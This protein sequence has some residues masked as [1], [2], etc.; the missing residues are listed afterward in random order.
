LQ[1]L[2]EKIEIKTLPRE[3]INPR[4]GQKMKFLKTGAE[5]NGQLLSIECYSP[6]STTIREPEHIHPHQENIFEIL[7]GRLHFR[8]SGKTITMGRGEVVVIPAHAPHHFWNESGAEA[9]Y[10]Q[11]FKPALNSEAF[12]RTYFTLAEQNKLNKKG[13]PNLL[14]ISKLCLRHQNEV[15]LARPSWPIQ[16]LIFTVFAPFGRL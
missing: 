9:H 2:D 13:K 7:D 8:I 15:R 6:S 10:I 12:F 11:K 1:I 3:I 16:K 5:T 4:T 14:R